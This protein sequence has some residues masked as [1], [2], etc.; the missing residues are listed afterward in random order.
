MAISKKIPHLK[1]GLYLIVRD[2]L[3]HKLETEKRWWER[4]IRSERLVVVGTRNGNRD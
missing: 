4:K 3:L 2:G 1:A